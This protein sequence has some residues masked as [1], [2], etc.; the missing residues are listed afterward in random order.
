MDQNEFHG[1]IDKLKQETG[2]SNED[3]VAKLGE[4]Y[5]DDKITKDQLIAMCGELG[6]EVDPAFA[7]APD[8]E[9]SKKLLWDTSNDEGQGMG[10]KEKEAVR[11]D[12]DGSN[13]P[14][15]P[16]SGEDEKKKAL[17]YFK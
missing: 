13:P 10:E 6:F 9:E 12:P 3:A 14:P 4:M 16:E 2:G 17:D 11:E 15:A 7:K 5:E 1:V 8:G